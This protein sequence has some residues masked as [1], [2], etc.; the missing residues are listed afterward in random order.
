MDKKLKEYLST[1]YQMEI[2]KD[3]DEGGYVV[4]YPELPG[5]IICAETIEEAL[6]NAVDAKKPG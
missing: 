2:I 4:Y 5:C 1:D 3:Q 6:E